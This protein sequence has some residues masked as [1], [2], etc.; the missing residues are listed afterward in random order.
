MHYNYSL[1]QAYRLITIINHHI[2]VESVYKA[3]IKSTFQLRKENS[4]I[5]TIF[6]VHNCAICPLVSTI[7]GII[8]AFQH[9]QITW[10]SR[11]TFLCVAISARVSIKQL[12]KTTHYA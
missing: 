3:H 9:S 10:N 6:E 7:T 12:L 2:E 11:D 4:N 5:L 8:I 1:A